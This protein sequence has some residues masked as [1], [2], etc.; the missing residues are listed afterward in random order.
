M[1]ISY[2]V[3]L[4]ALLYIRYHS[5]SPPLT[6]HYVSYFISTFAE[7]IPMHMGLSRVCTHRYDH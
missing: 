4:Y 3:H 7:T 1:D 5:H 2:L 6:R